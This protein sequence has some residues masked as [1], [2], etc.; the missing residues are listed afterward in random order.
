M[1]DI[2]FVDFTCVYHQ[3]IPNAVVACAV[4]AEHLHYLL[5][6][7]EASELVAVVYYA[8]CER[9][10]DVRQLLKHVGVGLVY[11]NGGNDFL[12][13]GYVSGLALLLRLLLVILGTALFFCFRSLIK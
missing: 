9:R 10:A 6:F 7:D 11:L 8:F 1:V 2:Q 5:A 12:C 3:I 13:Q 4:H